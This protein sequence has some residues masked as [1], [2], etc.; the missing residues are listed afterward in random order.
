MKA[1]DW[2]TFS[3]KISIKASKERVYKSWAT[4]E[5]ICEWFLREAV[6]KDDNGALR[7][8][9]ATIQKND[10]YSWKW[11]NWDGEEKGIILEANGDDYIAFSFADQAKVEVQLETVEDVTLL[12]LT[13][14]NIP[15]DDE[16]K[17]NIYCGCS[18]GWTFWLANLK[19]YLE[20]GILLHETDLGY[21]NG[22]LDC[23]EYVNV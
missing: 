13:Q 23:N 14:S 15:T 2:T 6:Y 11:H 9:S 18:N 12:K 22:Q 7:L 5:A 4:S 3:K 8:P 20:H 17:F 10:S 21:L 1:I 16:H 19:A